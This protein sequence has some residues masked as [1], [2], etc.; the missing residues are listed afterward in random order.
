MSQHAE[1]PKTGGESSQQEGSGSAPLTA[2]GE[3]VSNVGAKVK[4]P[5]VN[6]M[7]SGEGTEEESGNE[8]SGGH[9]QGKGMS[10]QT[11][12]SVSEKLG[13]ANITDNIT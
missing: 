7:G 6:L 12:K 4:K 2:I 13:D 10:G 9:E 11:L 3:T 5:F 8:R 1:K